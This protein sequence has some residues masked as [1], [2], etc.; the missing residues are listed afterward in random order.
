MNDRVIVGHG[1]R[2]S[3]CSSFHGISGIIVYIIRSDG[4]II[5][6]VRSRISGISRVFGVIIRVTLSNVRSVGQPRS[7]ISSFVG[8]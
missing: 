7:G 6:E 3:G 4:R 5:W 1:S 2:I 8:L